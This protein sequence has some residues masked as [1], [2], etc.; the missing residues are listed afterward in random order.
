MQ[1]QQASQPAGPAE[2]CCC[3]RLLWGFS[4]HQESDA[5]NEP[6]VL[7]Y[8]LG[9]GCDLSQ[10]KIY[11]CLMSPENAQ[12]QNTCRFCASKQNY[13]GLLVGCRA[14]THMWLFRI[15]PLFSLL[16]DF[17]AGETSPVTACMCQ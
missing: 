3:S 8:I 12:F 10:D 1:E 9:V 7:L 5:E 13:P 4:G 17:G 11:T 6:I 15:W 2:W 14:D 16:E